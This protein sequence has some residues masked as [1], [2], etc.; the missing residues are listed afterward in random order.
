M[1]FR[2][3]GNHNYC[4]PPNGAVTGAISTV[5]S[6]TSVVRNVAASP[7]VGDSVRSVDGDIRTIV[8]ID[9]NLPNPVGVKLSNGIEGSI[10]LWQWASLVMGAVQVFPVGEDQ[11]SVADNQSM[12]KQEPECACVSLL[13]GHETKCPMWRKI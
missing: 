4:C 2:M 3:S 10:E 8:S 13:W 12:S 6:Y 7:K 1:A 11:L 5:H 9:L